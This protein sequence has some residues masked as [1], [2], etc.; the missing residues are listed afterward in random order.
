MDTTGHLSGVALYKLACDKEW[1]DKIL[2]EMD[3]VIPD[4]N[5]IT[6]EKLNDL[7]YTNAFLS[8]CLRLYSPAPWIISRYAL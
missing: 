1:H 2:E 5:T 4:F 3:K 6:L 8:E 7:K